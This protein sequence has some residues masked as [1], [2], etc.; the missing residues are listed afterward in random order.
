[1]YELIKVKTFK[2][3]KHY[4]NQKKYKILNNPK[5]VNLFFYFSLYGSYV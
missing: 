3:K 2:K 1:M 5:K 4:K